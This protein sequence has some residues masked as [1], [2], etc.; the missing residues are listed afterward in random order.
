MS[1]PPARTLRVT[2]DESHSQGLTCAVDGLSQFTEAELVAIRQH[3]LRPVQGRSAAPAAAAAGAAESNSS[4][5]SAVDFSSGRTERQPRDATDSANKLSNMSSDSTRRTSDSGSSGTAN[6]VDKGATS[7][8][9]AE[10]NEERLSKKKMA[11]S[12]KPD[13]ATGQ[14]TADK[15]ANATPGT[16]KGAEPCFDGADA[17]DVVKVIPWASSSSSRRNTNKRMSGRVG[18]SVTAIAADAASDLVFAACSD[19]SLWKL[20]AAAQLITAGKNSLRSRSVRWQHIGAAQ[21]VVS[22]SFAAPYLFA[23][24]IEGSVWRM[25]VYGAAPA[26][27]PWWQQSAKATVQTETR[28][29]ICAPGDKWLYA[30]T[31]SDQLVK[32][33]ATEAGGDWVTVRD[34]SA[35]TGLA[36]RNQLLLALCEDGT[37]WTWDLSNGGDAAIPWCTLGDAPTDLCS[38]AC[39]NSHLFAAAADGTILISF[40]TSDAAGMPRRLTWASEGVTGPPALQTVAASSKAVSGGR[41]EQP[42]SKQRRRSSSNSA[43]DANPLRSASSGDSIVEGSDIKSNRGPIKKK[44][45]ESATSTAKQSAPTAAAKSTVQILVPP[46]VEDSTTK[47]KQ[48]DQPKQRPPDQ[49]CPCRYQYLGCVKILKNKHSE[50]THASTACKF[51]PNRPA[52]AD[53]NAVAPKDKIVTKA[54]APDQ[55]KQRPPDQPC[56]C[57]YQYLGCVKILKNKHSEATHASTACKFRPNRPS[58]EDVNDIAQRQ[59]ANML[60]AVLAVQ[61]TSPDSDHR[62]GEPALVA[63]HM[64]QGVSALSSSDTFHGQHPTA[65]TSTM[66]STGTVSAAA[67][68]FLQQQAVLNLDGSPTAKEGFGS[69]TSSPENSPSSTTKRKLSDQDGQSTVDSASSNQR[70]R[71][72]G[73]SAAVSPSTSAA[74]LVA[75]LAPTPAEPANAESTCAT[76]ITAANPQAGSGEHEAQQQTVNKSHLA[77]LM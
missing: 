1:A 68:H 37:L 36:S 43:A 63:T 24:D 64:R 76:R 28:L 46:K 22:M 27:E 57:R 18:V 13:A 33:S 55:P 61:S 77:F 3:F 6:S 53:V 14:K 72:D 4:P 71:L 40:L 66:Q 62:D 67:A 31:L 51:R 42:I 20:K 11:R 16:A 73:V 58:G 44:V 15:Q 65:G 5:Q 30:T 29:A 60:A 21:S 35:V 12:P 56:P 70:P 7:V 9:K 32:F 74:A 52:G 10:Q 45:P 17:V 59:A 69:D 8:V 49:P 41:I 48:K 75:A 50:A 2:F 34:A 25:D 26:W 38:L 23:L 19:N 54:P 47:M 39:S